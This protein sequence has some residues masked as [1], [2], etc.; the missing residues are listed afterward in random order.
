MMLIGSHPNPNPNPDGLE[1]PD[2]CGSKGGHGRLEAGRAHTDWKVGTLC[3]SKTVG[4]SSAIGE[5][6][7]KL[8]VFV[9][10]H[11]SF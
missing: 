2:P 7:G 4:R 5:N 9:K 8:S 3:R 6:I 11:G 10:K 1:D